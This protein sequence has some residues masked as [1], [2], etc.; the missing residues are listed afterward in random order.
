MSVADKT[1]YESLPTI[2]ELLA[3]P[4][5]RKSSSYYINNWFSGMVAI[6]YM[7]Y[8]ILIIITILIMFLIYILEKTIY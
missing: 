1:A 8:F 6:K 3:T 2:E 7:S 5:G 4:E